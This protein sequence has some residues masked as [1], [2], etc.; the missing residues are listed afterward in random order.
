MEDF[1]IPPVLEV[2][3]LNNELKRRDINLKLTRLFE[4]YNN[5]YFKFHDSIELN[6]LYNMGYL[7]KQP[8]HCNAH[9]IIYYDYDEI[10]SLWYIDYW[11][12]SWTNIEFICYLDDYENVLWYIEN[13]IFNN[14]YKWNIK[15]RSILYKL[16][17]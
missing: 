15:D 13:Y 1:L 6:V 9:F 8:N 4:K 2:Q 12:H 3:K 11:D 7:Y 10:I 14:Y 17:D 5:K 16:T